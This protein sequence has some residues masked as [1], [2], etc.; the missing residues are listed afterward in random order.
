MLV[1][2]MYFMFLQWVRRLHRSFGGRTA[3]LVARL[4]QGMFESWEVDVQVFVDDPCLCIAGTKF[5]QERFAAIVI[6]AW[7]AFGV[8]AGLPKGSMGT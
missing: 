4:T 2:F 8:S 1:S 3:V 7:R 6:L 5:E